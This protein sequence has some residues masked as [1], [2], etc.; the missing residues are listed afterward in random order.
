MAKKSM[1]ERQL[2]IIRQFVVEEGQPTGSVSA[3]MVLHSL[4]LIREWLIEWKH[5]KP[6]VPGIYIYRNDI[7]WVHQKIAVAKGDWRLAQNPEWFYAND[8][9][10]QGM[11]LGWW[12]GP[13]AQSP[14][15]ITFV[16]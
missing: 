15:E 4:E 3:Q 12:F 5:V 14:K 9:P 2:D 1:A 16:D 13:I 8:Q 7:E 10:L 6:T 11:P